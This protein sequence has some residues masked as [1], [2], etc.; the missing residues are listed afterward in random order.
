MQCV[1]SVHR[2]HCCQHIKLSVFF[3][4]VSLSSC[5]VVFLFA[6]LGTGMLGEEQILTGAE[7]SHLA[8]QNMCA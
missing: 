4:G 2:A 3:N 1:A 7:Q 6:I 5:Y 8:T